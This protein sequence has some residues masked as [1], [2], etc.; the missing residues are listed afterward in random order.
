LVNVFDNLITLDMNSNSSTPTTAQELID[1][2]NVDPAAAAIVT[3][4]LEG[5][6]GTTTIGE[7]EIT[8]SP[9]VLQNGDVEL[10]SRNDDYFSEDSRIELA[11][12][13]GTYFLGVSASGNDSYD[14]VIENTG[15]GGTTQGGYDLRSPSAA[16]WIRVVQSAIQRAASLEMRQSSLMATETIHQVAHTTSG[17]KHAH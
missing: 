4:S 7:R 3:A 9:I 5:G 16:R 12:N 13:S 2:V 14:P 15:F 8:F 1:A 17:S 10:I 11:L 6:D